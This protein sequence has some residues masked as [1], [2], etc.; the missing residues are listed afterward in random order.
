MSQQSLGS[1]A[2]KS[3]ETL[4]LIYDQT[5]AKLVPSHQPL[6]TLH[7]ILMVLVNMYLCYDMAYLARANHHFHRITVL[8]KKTLNMVID[9]F[10]CSFNCLLKLCFTLL[11][12]QALTVLLVG[13]SSQTAITNY[14]VVFRAQ[15]YTHGF[16]LM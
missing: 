15:T 6:L 12:F 16:H 14:L 4:I 10:N 5:P 7:V 11:Q 1:I 8:L 3:G 13:Q 9:V 2:I